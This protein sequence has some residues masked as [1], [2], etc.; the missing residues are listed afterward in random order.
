MRLLTPVL[1]GHYFW[2]HE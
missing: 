2:N 1:Y